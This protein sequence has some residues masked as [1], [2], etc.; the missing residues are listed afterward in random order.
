M[1]TGQRLLATDG[2]VTH[3]AR[4]DEIDEPRP[5][6]S[7]DLAWVVELA[8]ARRADIESF[9]PRFWKPAQDASRT[10]AAF[11]GSLIAEPD[12]LSIRTDHGFLFGRPRSGALVVD[13]MATEDDAFWSLDGEE[14][15]RSAG[16][17]GRLRLVCPVPE[18]L[19]ASAATAVGLS[20]AESW[21]HRD[22]PHVLSSPPDSE[23]LGVRVD[24]AVGRLVPAPP[25]YAPGGPVL[26]VAS[27]TDPNALSVI[28]DEAARRG[29]PVSVVSQKPD[30]DRLAELLT[31]AGY[32]RT[33]DYYEGRTSWCRY[34][35]HEQARHRCP[36]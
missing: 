30:D 8:S 33:T 21:W 26:L 16:Q 28:E 19:K 25:V 24:G 1:S 22:L 7:A 35:G 27:L 11:L 32:K 13:D 6:T 15:L 18:T 4:V 34:P 23:E 2:E 29:A 12:V 9:A 17:G 14:L 3:G 20:V 5:L 31:S 10:H 36:C